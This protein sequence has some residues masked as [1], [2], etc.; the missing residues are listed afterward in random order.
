VPIRGP[1]G[2]LPFSI[3]IILGPILR[4]SSM[5][6]CFGTRGVYS[7]PFPGDCQRT[8]S[9]GPFPPLRTGPPIKLSDVAPRL[10]RSGLFR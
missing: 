2:Y 7:Q 4:V 3:L 1:Y 10:V 5:I 8:S 6:G 9:T